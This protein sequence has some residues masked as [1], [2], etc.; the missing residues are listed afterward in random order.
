MPYEQVWV[1]NGFILG[2][3]GACNSVMKDAASVR[4]PVDVHSFRFGYWVVQSGG[5]SCREQTMS[6]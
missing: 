3:A 1:V 5:L 4:M 2:A 6:C